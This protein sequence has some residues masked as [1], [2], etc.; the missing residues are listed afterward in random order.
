MSKVKKVLA[1]ILS[2][3][4]ILGMSLTTFAAESNKIVVNNL[5]EGTTVKAVQVII[6]STG[7]E[8]GWAFADTDIANAYVTSLL[9]TGTQATPENCQKAIWMLLLAETPTLADQ[10]EELHIEIPADTNAATNE[11]IKNALA[12][13]PDAK[14]ILTPD[15]DT[16]NEFTVTSAGVYAIKAVPTEGS[17]TVY[18]PMAAYVGFVYNDDGTPTLPDENTDVNA[19]KTE[20]PVVKEAV[21]DD[22]ATGIDE[23]VT[24]KV[25]TAV[26]YGVSEWKFTDTIS[27]ATYVVE[28]QG[29]EHEGQ[30]KVSVTI[31][32]SQPQYEYATV[33]GNSFEL[34]LSSLINENNQGAEVIFTYQATVTGTEVNNKI[35]YGDG[36]HS[37]EFVNLYTGS[38]E[39]TKVNEDDDKLGGAGFKVSRTINGNTEYAVFEGTSPVYILKEWVKNIESATEIKTD[40]VAE[41]ETFGTLTIK[42]L[43]KGA[44]YHFIETTAPE[45]YSINEDGISVTFDA[46][47]V[48]EAFS[49]DAEMTD[50]KLSSLPLPETG[51]MGTT[52]F[53]IGGCVIMI[54]AA[55]LY[56]ASRRKESK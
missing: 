54:A 22:N 8:T 33:T 13:I 47:K 44:T 1:I 15:V 43:D 25:T 20:V 45:G 51:G 48:T 42:G 14:Y 35:S 17:D 26:P 18:N 11:Q 10:Q 50:T 28:P 4:M 53:T 5:E 16:T 52:I 21:D 34:D 19:K 49:K 7:T 31:G 9:G 40:N 46:G 12:A 36:E 3:A 32:T 56:F 39:F 2:M 38:I 37:S 6:P 23:T 41:N 30:V 29:S 24:Y 55:G 27:G